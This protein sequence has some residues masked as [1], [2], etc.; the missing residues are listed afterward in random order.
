MKRIGYELNKKA[1]YIF[2]KFGIDLVRSSANFLN[3]DWVSPV[4]FM[5][6][7]NNRHILINVPLGDIRFLGVHGYKADKDSTAPFISTIKEYKEGKIKSYIN[8]P[9]YSF[10]SNFQPKSISEYLYLNNYSSSI[11]NTL[12]PSGAF[13]PWQDIDPV[14]KSRQRVLE[15]ESDN[16]EHNTNLSMEGGDPFYGPVSLEK[17]ELEYNRLINIYYSILKHGFKIDSKGKGNIN[18]VIL[19]NDNN[20]CYFVFSGQH[21]VAALSVLNYEKVPIQI[22]K[23]L[24]V[25]RSEVDFWPGV[26]N[27]YFS[28]SEALNVFDRIFLGKN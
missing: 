7:T 1:H 26:T 4:E 2:N 6:K 25:R 23:G 14:E 28:K 15:V 21:R 24:V 5:Y 9:L 19:E 20:Y 8:S 11:F 18:A 17:G 10:Y 13:L 3:V 22:Y 27:G 16:K 12:P